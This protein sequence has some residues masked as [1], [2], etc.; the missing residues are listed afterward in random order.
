MHSAP[1]GFLSKPI[2]GTAAR[3]LGGYKAIH[4]LEPR[5]EHV[6]EADVPCDIPDPTQ[7]MPED[8]L[9]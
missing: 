7:G 6:W 3:D 9:S 4:E 5:E 2:N 1:G 8:P